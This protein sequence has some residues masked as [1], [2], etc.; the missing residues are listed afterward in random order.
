MNRWKQRKYLSIVPA[1]LLLAACASSQNS[2]SSPAI[3]LQNV[4]LTS[5]DFSVQTFLLGFAVTNPNP[6]PLPINSVA[7]RVALDGHQFAGGNA[8]GAFTIPAQ[9]DGEFVIS[10]EL[11]LLKTAPQLLFIVRDSV[12]RRVPYELRGEL[13]V[14]IPLTGPV[15]FRTSGEIRLNAGELSRLR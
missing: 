5:V 15:S 9:S 14:D 11:D 3:S 12:S 8:P 2:I 4:Q 7:Y 10:V 1:V 6:F 13:G